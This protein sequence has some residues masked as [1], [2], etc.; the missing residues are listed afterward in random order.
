MQ[1]FFLRDQGVFHLKEIVRMNYDYQRDNPQSDLGDF[2]LNTKDDD[3]VLSIIEY[4]FVMM[5]E[6]Q[7]WP[8]AW[9]SSHRAP[10]DAIKELNLRFQQSNL[11]FKFQERMLIQ[12]DSEEL[13]KEIVRPS[14]SKLSSDKIYKGAD[15]EYREA[16]SFYKEGKYEQVLIKCNNAVESCLK[17]ICKK[18]SW[19]IKGNSVTGDL[20]SECKNNGLFPPLT[21]T[22]LAHL[23]SLT[24]SV[25]AIRGDS[26]AHAP[27]DEGRNVTFEVA[28]YV[29]HLTATNIIFLI[30]CERA[31]K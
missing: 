22:H 17:A 7:P 24:K 25:S 2:F 13:H 18:H 4:C 11:G 5:G 29:L 6:R 27:D 28:S 12:I 1:K 21:G 3:L 31:L 30:E 20:I 15:G 9:F 26:A 8:S 23:T 16:F 10:L 14:L 19:S